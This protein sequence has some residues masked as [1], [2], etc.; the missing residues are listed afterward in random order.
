MNTILFE[1]IHHKCSDIVDEKQLNDERAL[2]KNLYVF[3]LFNVENEV[4]LFVMWLNKRYITSDIAIVLVFVLNILKFCYRRF[5]NGKFS[6]HFAS[7]FNYEKLNFEE[8]L[9]VRKFW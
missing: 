3:I 9:G 2:M 6:L 5:P 8:N 4:I 1:F 7:S